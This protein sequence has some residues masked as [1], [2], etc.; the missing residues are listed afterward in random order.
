MRMI[1]SMG[2]DAVLAALVLVPLFALLDRYYFH[3][4]R[5]TVGFFLLAVYLSGVFAVVGL[6]DIRYIRFDFN[7]NFVPF[8]YMFSDFR[9]SFLNVLLFVPLGFFLP[10]FWKIFKKLRW[11][12]LFG[13]C[14]SVLIELLQIFTFRATDIND[15]ITNTFGTMLGWC[16]GRLLLKLVPGIVPG[17]KVQE[18]Y[19]VCGVTFATMFF[20]HP[21]L[22]EWV[23][24]YVSY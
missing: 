4:P 18:V 17:E 5:R 2:L 21:F 9:S 13:L 23:F 22:A 7:H 10:L 20:I 1:F 14:A 6:P 19:V 16:L 8:R 11:T 24:L 15:L 12:L 3:N